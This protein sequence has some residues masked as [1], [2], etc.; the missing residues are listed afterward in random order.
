MPCAPTSIVQNNPTAVTSSH[1][2]NEIQHRQK[3]RGRPDTSRGRV[4]ENCAGWGIGRRP[5]PPPLSG[6]PRRR[7]PAALA[8]ALQPLPPPPAPLSRSPRRRSPAAPPPAAGNTGDRAPAAATEG[9]GVGRFLRRHSGLLHPT[10]SD[11]LQRLSPSIPSP[12]HWP[13]SSRPTPTELLLIGL[14]GCAI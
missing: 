9:N 6:R 5:P 11:G 10:P 13:S 8:S 12:P 7:S 3:L 4:G 2:V 14:R 1:P